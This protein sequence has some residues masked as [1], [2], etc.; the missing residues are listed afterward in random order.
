[1][2]R[3]LTWCQ[4]IHTRIRTQ[5]P[6]AMLARTIDTAKRLLMEKNTELVMMRHL[7]HQRHEQLVVVATQISLLIDRSQLK[8][9]RCHLIVTCL[10]RNT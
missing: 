1:M 8:L 5:R 4:E 7:L 2:I 9:V 3:I 6:V 10:D